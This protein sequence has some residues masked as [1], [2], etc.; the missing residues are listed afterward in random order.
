MVKS[1]I[2]NE[3]KHL[4]NNKQRV[5]I[6]PE[7]IKQLKWSMTKRLSKYQSH[8]IINIIFGIIGILLIVIS[9][10]VN[11]N[12][13]VKN[14]LISLGTGLIC[15]SILAIAIE[16]STQIHITKL[17]RHK[18][19]FYIVKI[20]YLI[21]TI[22]DKMFK[23]ISDSNQNNDKIQKLADYN[24]LDFLKEYNNFFVQNLIFNSSC[25]ECDIE[26]LK[27][28]FINFLGDAKDEEFSKIVNNNEFYTLDMILNENLSLFRYDNL[29]NLIEDIKSLLE[30][31]CKLNEF[32]NLRELKIVK[33]KKYWI[34][35]CNNLT[36]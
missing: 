20:E 24:L 18:R 23:E 34:V 2:K 11:I 3:E 17:M 13:D 29:F 10:F 21:R 12:T 4:G 27:N 25:F 7:S 31:V 19:N 14:L 16:V 22:L 35:R 36:F 33:Q 6:Y 28:T 30:L 8:Y 26:E 15:S 5:N 9:F 32:H 1:S